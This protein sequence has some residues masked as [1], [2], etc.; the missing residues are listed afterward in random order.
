MAGGQDGEK[1]RQ[2]KADAAQ[3]LNDG[4][5]EVRKQLEGAEQAV[6]APLVVL[7]DL[8]VQVVDLLTFGLCEIEIE[9][10]VGQRLEARGA[11]PTALI[12]RPAAQ[13]AVAQCQ[14]RRSG[15]GQH[16]P[17]CQAACILPAGQ[18]ADDPGRQPDRHIGRQRPARRTQQR[19]DKV[20]AAFAEPHPPRPQI[21]PP[22]LAAAAVC[23]RRFRHRTRLLPGNSGSAPQTAVHSRRPAPAAAH[24]CPVRRCARARGTRCG[25]RSAWMPAGG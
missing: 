19:G 17:E 9:H 6:A 25:R 4:L 12:L 18:L 13:R 8:I 21:Q 1:E 16:S 10:L 7:P 24:G 11:Q 14:Q 2:R 22:R 20:A 15:H 5:A 23:F 3:H